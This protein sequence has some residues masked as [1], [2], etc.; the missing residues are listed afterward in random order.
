MEDVLNQSAATSSAPGVAVVEASSPATA[1]P[2]KRNVRILRA[3]A[4]TPR[5]VSVRKATGDSSPGRPTAESVERGA[6]GLTN[7][8]IEPPF[9]LLKLAMLPE[10]STVLTPLIDAM[11]INIDGFGWRP[12]PRFTESHMAELPPDVKKAMAA[13]RRE[14]LNFFNNCSVRDTFTA[15]RRKTR[16]D[17]EATGNGYWEIVPNPITGAL[18]GIEHIES[19]R[20]RC[21]KLCKE[22]VPVKVPVVEIGDDDRPMIA[23]QSTLRRFRR[24]AQ[25]DEQ[26]SKV[27]VWFKEYGD[28][29]RLSRTTGR[30]EGEKEQPTVEAGDLANEVFHWKLYCP[31]SPYGLPRTVGNFITIHGDRAADEIN[32]TTLS[33]NNIPSMMMLVSNGQ[34]T[35]ATVERLEEF[36]TENQEGSPNYS[37]ILIIEAQPEFEGPDAATPQVKIERMTDQQIKD[38]LFG[39]YGKSNA[40]KLRQSFRLP[41]LYWGGS[42]DYTRSTADASRKLAD[43]QVFAPERQAEDGAITKHFLPRMGIRYTTFLSLGPNTTNDQDLINAMAGGERSGGMTP[44]IAHRIMSDIMGR[45][46]PP[47]SKE[48]DLDVPYSLQMAREVKNMAQPN[49]VGQ[50]VTALKAANPDIGAWVERLLDV[51]G[52]LE[53]E[54]DRLANA[55]PHKH[56]NDEAQH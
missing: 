14:M 10:D 49:E 28:P 19:H 25:L 23:R 3:I 51:R 53:A 39:E 40:A 11:E 52:I 22:W 18:Q 17:Y 55:A 42:D 33:Q 35:P 16:H 43:E 4:I 41:P 1:T 15:I 24:Y 8:L 7:D 20:M 48:I 44:R 26:G 56:D 9:H 5:S 37:R 54:M 21:T 27:V 47:V 32:Y 45:E 50:Q 38:A 12:E 46:L 34:L 36:V 6:Q 29:R 13:E 31:R 30:F 2:D